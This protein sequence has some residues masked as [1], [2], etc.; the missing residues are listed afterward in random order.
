[1]QTIYASIVKRTADELL[2]KQN[3]LDKL[4]VSR[5]AVLLE[6]EQNFTREVN[7]VWYNLA[8][9][10]PWIGMRTAD[11]NGAHV[12][13]F[14]G[15]GNPIALKIGPAM[16]PET[17]L[18]L[19]TRLNPDNEPGRLTLIHRIGVDHVGVKL[20]LLIKAVM[21]A[22]FT[23]VWI[24]DPMHG[25][26]KITND[27]KTCHFKDILSELVQS[28]DIHEALGSYLGGIHLEMT[29]DDVTECLSGFQTLTT[30]DL[31]IAYKSPIDPRL[32]KKQTLDL[33]F[34]Y[35]IY[36]FKNDRELFKSCLQK[37]DD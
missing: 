15:I 25:N 31:T 9:H 22:G 13:Y 28:Y 14:R 23:V 8:T 2:K 19:I 35:A 26:T 3:L 16:Q 27:I 21:E 24:C 32:N 5:E 17:L 20:P 37:L 4:F 12:E 36:C 1:L 18:K 7:G 30:A 29:G 6:Y 11:I 34:L 33:M 10:F